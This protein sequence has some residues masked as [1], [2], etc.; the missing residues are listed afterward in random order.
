M[1]RR[2]EK[3]SHYDTPNEITK[4]CLCKQYLS[5]PTAV[6]TRYHIAGIPV[7]RN[8]AACWCND[9]VP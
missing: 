3:F 4:S 9:L 5:A 7:G 2:V 1:L 6:A 8:M